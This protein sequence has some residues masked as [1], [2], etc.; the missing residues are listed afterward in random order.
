MLFRS[1]YSGGGRK[2]IEDYE[3]ARD[4]SPYLPYGL[5]YHHKHLPE[6]ARYAGLS[7]AP[8]FQPV[9]GAFAQGMLTFVPIDLSATAKRASVA[10]LHG[11]LAE[12]YAGAT[13][14]TVAPLSGADR[15]DGLDPRALNG[16]N[17]MRLHVF[18]NDA[19]GQAMLVAQ[20]DNLG[21]GASGAAVQNLNLMLGLDPAAGLRAA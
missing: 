6:M 15:V 11:V 1:G 12:R 19:A 17:A 13:F 4:P 18:G 20:Y 10:D 9:V 3:A 2:M 8:I 7:R 21:K 5:T 16:T 14:V